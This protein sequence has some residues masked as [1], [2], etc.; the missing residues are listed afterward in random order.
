MTD[1]RTV[2]KAGLAGSIIP[3]G[4][5]ASAAAA[6]QPL[7]IHRAVYDRPVDLHR[8]GGDKD[9]ACAAAAIAKVK[10]G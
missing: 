8:P 3:L 4:A 2:L 7:K 5:V 6:A 10:L 1:R 9:D